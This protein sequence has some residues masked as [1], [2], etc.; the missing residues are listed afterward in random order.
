MNCGT[1]NPPWC[2]HRAHT[3]PPPARDA[4][5][6]CL[7]C[8]RISGHLE[9]KNH[10]QNRKKAAVAA[11]KNLN[12]IGQTLGTSTPTCCN[13]HQLGALDWETKPLTTRNCAIQRCHGPNTVHPPCVY[14]NRTRSDD[15]WCIA[16]GELK[17]IDA[18]PNDKT[19]IAQT[20]RLAMH[21][22]VPPRHQPDEPQTHVSATGRPKLSSPYPSRTGR[23]AH[24]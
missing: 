15:T 10:R 6:R 24:I 21:D 9:N 2:L 7:H 19:Q 23:F 14:P 5:T 22:A 1:T 8:V 17:R 18:A 3:S 11:D 16:H 20:R 4:P 13:R 12:P